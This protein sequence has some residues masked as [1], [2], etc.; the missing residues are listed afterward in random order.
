MKKLMLSAAMSL[1]AIVPSAVLACGADGAKQTM[2]APAKVE[3]KQLASLTKE[4]KA[5]AVDVNDSETRR[6]DGVIPGAIMLTSSSQYE[7]K[8]LPADKK[9]N[10]VFYCYNEQCGASHGAAK[11]AME[12]G[13]TNVS[14]LPAGIKGW[15]AAGQPTSKPNS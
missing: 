1:A 2:A 6:N 5:T 12:S 3:V 14:V 7:L 11:R 13:Y 8:E 9:S 15:K 4:K 10:L